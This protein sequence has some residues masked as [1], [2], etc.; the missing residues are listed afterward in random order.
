MGFPLSNGI[1][2]YQ[3]SFGEC[4]G[5]AAGKTLEKIPMGFELAHPLCCCF[6]I[7]GWDSNSNS[8]TLLELQSRKGSCESSGPVKEAQWGDQTPAFGSTAGCLKH[9]VTRQTSNYLLLFPQEALAKHTAVERTSLYRL[10]WKI[11]QF[12][13]V[14]CKRLVQALITLMSMHKSVLCTSPQ[15]NDL[16]G[17]FLGFHLCHK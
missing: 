16:L 13:M 17:M 5:K 4:P 12:W 7:A 3:S 1:G 9:W 14:C 11:C 10:L 6:L 8:S 2:F 15:G